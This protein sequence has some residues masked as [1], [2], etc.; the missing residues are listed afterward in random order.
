[1]TGKSRKI[2]EINRVFFQENMKKR[3][4]WIAI[5]TVFYIAEPLKD[6]CQLNLAGGSWAGRVQ[7]H[8]PFLILDF[9][10]QIMWAKVRRK[11]NPMIASIAKTI[12]V[13]RIV[14]SEAFCVL[15]CLSHSGWLR[16]NSLTDSGLTAYHPPR[17]IIS[18]NPAIITINLMSS[19]PFK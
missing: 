17:I 14:V 7:F 8:R 19:S 1:M 9:V 3:K 4:P 11:N 18:I 15:P 16:Q 5:S 2:I 13:T 6:M 10:F 12:P